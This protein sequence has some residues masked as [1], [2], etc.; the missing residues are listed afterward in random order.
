MFFEFPVEIMK[1]LRFAYCTSPDP[2]LCTN[3]KS[4]TKVRTPEAHLQINQNGDKECTRM[5]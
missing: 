3:K 5:L 1:L 2:D 4:K